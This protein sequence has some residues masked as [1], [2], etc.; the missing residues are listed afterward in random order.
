MTQRHTKNGLMRKAPKVKNKLMSICAIL[1]L[2]IPTVC[3]ANQ[4]PK[5]VVASRGEA[6][7]KTVCPEKWEE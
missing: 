2:N 3:R 4:A 1:I 7:I 6:F 5:T